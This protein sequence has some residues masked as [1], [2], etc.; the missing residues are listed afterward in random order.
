MHRRYRIGYLDSTQSLLITLVIRFKR[1]NLAMKM[2]YMITLAIF[3]VGP[4]CAGTQKP[5]PGCTALYAAKDKNVDAAP[6][7]MACLNELP[8]GAR[9]ELFPGAYRL[10]SPVTISQSV[11]IETK[12]AAPLCSKQTGTNCAQMLIGQINDPTPG[13]MPIEVTGDDVSV[14]SVAILA[15]PDRSD[16]WADETCKGVRRPLGG[17]IRVS[18]NNFHMSNSLLRG[19]SCFTALEIV[20]DAKAP[21]LSGNVIGPNGIHDQDQMWADG[22]TVHDTVGAQIYDNFFKDNTDIQLILGGCRSCNIKNNSFRHTQYHR[23]ASFAEIMIHA[24]PNTS[25]DYSDSLVAGNSID[26][27]TAKRCGYGIMIGGGPWYP[28]KT[29]GGSVIGNSVANAQMGINV[30]QLTGTMAVR[31]NVVIKSGGMAKSDCGTRSWPSVNISPTSKKF[32]TTDF[33]GYSSMK[34]LG[35][36]LNR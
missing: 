17:G 18:G 1:K 23:G 26:C 19:M 10:R 22:V 7:L 14:H 31:G 4:A 16:R 3:V 33:R 15:D 11:R 35:C 2:S 5:P 34:T 25:G 13:I 21:R 27:G 36:L 20:A 6:A 8:S 28:A 9:L 32:A 24:W 30:D 29:S 12:Q